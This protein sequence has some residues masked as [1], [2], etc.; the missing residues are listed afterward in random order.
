MTP[1]PPANNPQQL[2]EQM[3][4]IRAYEEAIVNGSAAGRMPGTCTS[5][6]QEAAAVGVVNA[7]AAEDLILTNH[8]SAGHLLARGADP[9]RLLAEVMGRR[10]GYCKGKSGSLHISAKELGVVLT[11]TIVGAELSM[12]PGVALAQSMLGRPG[13]VVCFF[14]D[15]AAC[16]GSFHESLNLAAL[17]NL[18]ILYVCENN[19]WQAFVHRR[20]AMSREHVAEWATG[21]GIPART[22]DGNDVFAVL[23]A[24]QAA[25]AQVRESGRPCL[26]ETTTY[27]TRGHLEPDDQGY[28]DKAELAN[29]LARDP[30][31][32]SRA[33][34]LADGL[35][36][37]AQAAAMADEVASRIA[38]AQAF[39]EAS[40]FPAADELTRDAYA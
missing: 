9:G 4:L 8:R 29:W 34:L 36:S 14:G 38:V 11:S 19:H 21:Y 18:P 2:L 6:G 30:I 13:I 28:V 31:T 1:K 16:E 12:A 40:P 35:L 23:E 17:W 22:V 20:E 7:L 26:L 5:V 10:D 27:R 25:A 15:G 39:A 32:T 33:R 3:L 24:A 37:Q